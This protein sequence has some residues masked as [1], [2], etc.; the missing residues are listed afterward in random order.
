VSFAAARDGKNAQSLSRMRATR[1]IFE[2][3]IW[4]PTIEPSR[5]KAIAVST[6][7]GVSNG[8]E[9]LHSQSMVLLPGAIADESPPNSKC[10]SSVR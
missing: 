8:K 5:V 10:S 9:I 3:E 2:F 1:R 7:E 6:A 4:F